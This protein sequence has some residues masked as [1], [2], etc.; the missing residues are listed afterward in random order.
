VGWGHPLPTP[1][2]LGRFRRPDLGAYGASTPSS[3]SLRISGYATVSCVSLLRYH[4]VSSHINPRYRV[5]AAN[6]YVRLARGPEVGITRRRTSYRFV[7]TNTIEK[8]DV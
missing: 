3:P 5:T 2:L 4:T 7:F 1:N 8:I 6:L